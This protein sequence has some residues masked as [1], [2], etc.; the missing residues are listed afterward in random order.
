MTG[1]K[2]VAKEN[3]PDRDHRQDIE[4]LGLHPH[5]SGEKSR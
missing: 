2:T 3:W 1:R 4:I 5:P